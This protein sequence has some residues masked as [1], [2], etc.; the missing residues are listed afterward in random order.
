MPGGLEIKTSPNPP[1]IAQQYKTA[2][3]YHTVQCVSLIAPYALSLIRG[4]MI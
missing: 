4:L 2:L 1:G 3:I